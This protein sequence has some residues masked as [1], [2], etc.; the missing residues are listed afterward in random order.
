MKRTLS[1]RLLAASAFLAVLVL[2]AGALNGAAAPSNRS[3]ATLKVALI[4]E[5]NFEILLQS[6]QIR[7]LFDFDH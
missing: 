2:A 1:R 5:L 3:A 7:F 4:A 6:F